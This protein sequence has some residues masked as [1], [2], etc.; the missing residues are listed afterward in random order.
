LWLLLE[1][2]EEE[3]I[4]SLADGGVQPS[5]SVEI[6]T[7]SPVVVGSLV[8]PLQSTTVSTSPVSF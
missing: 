5:L 3:T 1:E 6:V 8:T 2:D 7:P 4:S